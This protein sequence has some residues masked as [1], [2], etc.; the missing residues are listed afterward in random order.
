MTITKPKRTA[1]AILYM[2]R[3]SLLW[4][5]WK[6]KFDFYLASFMCVVGSCALTKSVYACIASQ[7][8]SYV[9]LCSHPQ[10]GSFRISETKNVVCFFFVRCIQCVL[11]CFECMWEIQTE[12][13]SICVISLLHT[14]TLF[15]FRAGSFI[16]FT[17]YIKKKEFVFCSAL[18]RFVSHVKRMFG[19]LCRIYLW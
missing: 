12:Q 10:C 13:T 15:R 2:L 1:F 18:V 14:W 11:L 8:F 9:S 16:F 3:I 4:T 7:W 19:A 17:F 5:I 6:K